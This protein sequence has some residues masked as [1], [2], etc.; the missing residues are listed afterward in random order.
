MP[1][2]DDIMRR[3]A[4]ISKKIREIMEELAKL[5]GKQT[6]DDAMFMKKPY[7]PIACASCEKNLI[8]I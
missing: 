3:F 1:N 2:K 7:G 8:N 6:E 5:G 4:Q